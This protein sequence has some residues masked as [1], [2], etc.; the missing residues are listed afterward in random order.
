MP[1]S[2]TPFLDASKC[3]RVTLSS[4]RTSQPRHMDDTL[5]PSASNAT[6]RTFGSSRAMC[7]NIILIKG[8]RGFCCPLVDH[9]GLWNGHTSPQ[10]PAVLEADTSY[11]LSFFSPSRIGLGLNWNLPN[12]GMARIFL[13]RLAVCAALQCSKRFKA[14]SSSRR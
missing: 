4:H 9:I 5:S 12:F 2:L 7:F 1:L 6:S 3:R 13:L 10:V 8:P 11:F 14:C